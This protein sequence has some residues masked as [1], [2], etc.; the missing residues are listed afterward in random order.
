MDDYLIASTTPQEVDIKP[1]QPVFDFTGTSAHWLANPVISHFFNALSIFIP[2]SEKMVIDILRKERAHIDDPK[3]QA[4][5]S[6]LIKQEGAHARLHRQTN[7]LLIKSGFGAIPPL[8]KAQETGFK[9]LGKIIPTATIPAAFEHF[10]SALSWAYLEN[11]GEWTGGKE[12]GFIDFL[13]WHAMEEIEHQAVCYDVYKHHHPQQSQL[14]SNTLLYIW[15]PL[16]LVSVYGA[17]GYL[18]LRDGS[19]KKKSE[20]RHFVDWLKVSA[21]IFWRGINQYKQPQYKAWS[22]QQ[23][24]RYTAFKTT[25]EKNL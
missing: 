6:A 22:K 1:R 9:L 19:L 11:R 5:I 20:R 4:E 18:L 25:L 23:I 2:V 24:L 3:L 16:T 12:N 7:A 17:Q 15:L 8:I 14:L 13:D 10:T 21:P